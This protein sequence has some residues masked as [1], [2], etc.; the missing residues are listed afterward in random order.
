MELPGADRLTAGKR[1]F[2]W[3]S[4]LGAKEVVEES[5][6]HKSIF[7]VN[8]VLG[9]MHMS[10]AFG[11]F[12]LIVVGKLETSSYLHD[13]VNLPHL[14]VFFRY[15]FPEEPFR[16]PREFN[17]AMIMDALLLFVLS[18][19]ALAWIKRLRSRWLGMKKTTKHAVGDRI[20]LS[21]LWLIFPARLL[22]ES[23]TCGLYATGSFLTHN[24]GRGLVRLMGPDVLQGFEL[25]A[26]W[27]YSIVLGVFFF[28][29]PHSR[30]MHIFTEVPHIFM[31]NWGVRSG[32]KP[33]S[34]DNFQIQACSRCGVCI[35]PCQLQTAAGIDNVQSAYF[36][37]ERRYGFLTPDVADNCLMC[38]RCEAKCPVHLDLN[39]LRI[40]SRAAHIVAPTAN[41][42]AYIN[43]VDTSSGEGKT[44][45]FAGCMTLLSPAIL[46]SMQQ[47][48]T[49]AGENVWWAD[50]DGGVCCGR[51]LKLSGEVDAARRMMNFNDE[52]FKK[53][54][55]TTLVTSCPIC[56]K[57]FRE[58]YELNGI[59]VL[60]HSQYILR[61][62]E[63]GR[64]ALEKGDERLTYH[65]PCELGRGLNI[66]AE[67]R[68][69]VRRL[70]TL[71]EPASHGSDA[72][73]C[74]GSVANLSLSSQQEN[75]IAAG[76]IDE[77][78][79]TGATAV[80]TA[81][82]QCK[83]SLKRNTSLPVRDLAEVVAA[84]LR[85]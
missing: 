78:R 42:Y 14:H 20:A 68:E 10:L 60:H 67:P 57:V 26:W 72:L 49:A 3:R 56:L 65:D 7:K 76:A 40:N 61:L 63:Q 70:G 36:L 1:M 81:C 54:G 18:G 30:Y 19:V 75:R 32:D 71:R 13:P 9:Y 43:G 59:E 31:R 66:Y 22:A 34:I 12:L 25:P 2:T 74:G 52:L 46:K 48:F 5:L 41:R 17:Y 11:W 64:I 47:I 53:H 51:P 50:R 35:D 4:V 62:A 37:R 15:F 55:I 82:P 23:T 79:A 84:R 28:S 80:V 16:F 45:Y 83:S 38:G 24:T 69:V 33:S 27:I 44:G 73:C 21:S 29:M 85:S 77:F 58:D 8:P 39:N 6:L